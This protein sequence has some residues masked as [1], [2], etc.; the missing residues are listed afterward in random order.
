MNSHSP[1]LTIYL[2]SYA[3]SIYLNKY[4]VSATIF[5]LASKSY[6]VNY[7]LLWSHPKTTEMLVSFLSSPHMINHFQWSFFE[8]V[9]LQ[10]HTPTWPRVPVE[11][12]LVRE[13]EN[14]PRCRFS[15][16]SAVK[17]KGM[18]ENACGVII[19]GPGALRLRALHWGSWFS[20]SERILRVAWPLVSTYIDSSIPVFFL[21]GHVSCYQFESGV[22][23]LNG[24]MERCGINNLVS[25][26][27]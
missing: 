2:Y 6:Y 19:R 18:N 17:I 1:L 4:I 26:G 7:V 20:W 22:S 13:G 8:G 11:S 21:I 23:H 15:F 16:C 3:F 25:T 5:I 9:I 24:T 12:D 14:S 27:S 10:K